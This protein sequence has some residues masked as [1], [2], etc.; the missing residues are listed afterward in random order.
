MSA[1]RWSEGIALRGELIRRFASMGA[2]I[3]HG[4]PRRRPV[5]PV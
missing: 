4:Y 1:G 3:D 2:K 5:V